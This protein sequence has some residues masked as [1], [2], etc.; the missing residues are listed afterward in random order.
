MP[1]SDVASLSLRV[2]VTMQANQ[3]MYIHKKTTLG[4]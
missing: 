4:G 2:P 3:G 1:V